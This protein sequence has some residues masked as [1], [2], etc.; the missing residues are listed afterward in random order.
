MLAGKKPPDCIAGFSPFIV[1]P[2]PGIKPPDCVHN[3]RL[4]RLGKIIIE[5]LTQDRRADGRQVEC[6]TGGVEGA[7]NFRPC[8][9]QE[10]HGAVFYDGLHESANWCGTR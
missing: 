7:G 2:H 5:R 6:L 8:R 3:F 9:G 4:L 10:R 1:S